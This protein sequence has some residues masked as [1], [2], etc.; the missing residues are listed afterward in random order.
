[1]QVRTVIVTIAITALAFLIFQ[2]SARAAEKLS[3][4]Y[5]AKCE[6]SYLDCRTDLRFA[7]EVS[8]TRWTVGDN[9]FPELRSSLVSVYR[10]EYKEEG[11]VKMLECK[12]FLGATGTRVLTEAEFLDTQT[13]CTKV[14]FPCPTGWK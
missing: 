2:T 14:C 4:Y 1:M 9:K 13:R 3:G 10:C 7:I 8:C 6:E 5:K 12:G 11:G